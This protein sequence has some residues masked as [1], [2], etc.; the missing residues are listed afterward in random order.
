[1]AEIESRDEENFPEAGA[2][3]IPLPHVQVSPEESRHGDRIIQVGEPTISLTSKSTQEHPEGNIAVNRD[4]TETE[5]PIF[6]SAS[7]CDT[8]MMECLS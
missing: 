1:M 3:P 2:N 6:N 8:W 4:D 5:E 7:D